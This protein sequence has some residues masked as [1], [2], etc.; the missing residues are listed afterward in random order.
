MWGFSNRIVNEKS[1]EIELYNK[2]AIL[3]QNGDYDGALTI[4][5]QLLSIN[6]NYR[7]AIFN[8]A[9]ITAGGNAK[10]IDVDM[11]AYYYYKV[12]SLEHPSM[13]MMLP[14]LEACDRGGVGTAP[15]LSFAKN[16]YFRAP[17]SL[18]INPFLMVFVCRFLGY[19]CVGNKI[20]HIVIGAE[21]DYISQKGNALS[22]NFLKS[23]NVDSEN[24][25]GY[26]I[27]ATDHPE[28]DFYLIYKFFR[29]LIDLFKSENIEEKYIEYFHCTVIS[30]LINR[31]GYNA[32]LDENLPGLKLFC[33]KYGY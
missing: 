24:Y 4:F 17:E 10:Y 12:A 31:S 13:V 21:L 18:K 11:C 26:S 30:Y 33:E 7:S 32:S 14:I 20:S 6:P 3:L 19:I 8:V 5:N 28:S 23:L 9:Q 2:G 16:I 22:N 29:D 1:D 15:L 27:Y 25:E